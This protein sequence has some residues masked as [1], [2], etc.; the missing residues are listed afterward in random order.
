VTSMAD[1]SPGSAG[2]SAGMH[3]L[4]I[5]QAMNVLQ[6]LQIAAPIEKTDQLPAGRPRLMAFVADAESEASLQACLSHLSFADARVRRGGIAKAIQHLGVERSPESL[7]V[8]ISGAEL[9]TSR[10]HDLAD[11]CEPGV[12]VIAVGN[13]NDVGLYRDLVQAGVSEYIV[14]PVTPQ[15]LAKALSPKR[16]AGEAGPISRKLGKMVAVVGARGGVGT[17]T[18]AVNLARHLADRQ[19]RRIALVDLDLQNGDCALTLNLKPTP[20]LREALSNPLRIDSVF[21]E[22]TM[23]VHG[24]RLFVLSSEEPLRDEV[25]FTAEAVDRLVGALRTRFHYVIVDVPRIPTAP[26]RRALDMADLRIIVADQ[27]LRSVR[28][29]V[30][31]CAALGEAEAEH[32]NLLVINRSGEGGRRAVTLEEMATVIA[33]RPEVVIPFQPKLFMTADRPRFMA[34]P[35]GRFTEAV[36]ALAV[37]V[38]GRTPERHRW[39]RFAS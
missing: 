18:L 1:R 38:S 14:K 6:P 10:M 23:V 5:D 24:E 3:D 9:P 11:V 27:T 15:L 28:D 13:R 20:G 31:L 39:W 21:L 36:A 26:Y 34:T 7:I 33:V 25:D 4:S 17:T 30:R 2:D 19:N 32:D 22:R 29:T 12:T 8:D 37:A 16:F 35:R